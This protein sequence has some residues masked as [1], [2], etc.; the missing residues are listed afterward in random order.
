MWV[1]C[2]AVGGVWCCG[3]S[4]VQLVMCHLY[5]YFNFIASALESG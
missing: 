2:G 1:E 5:E 3:W 4:V